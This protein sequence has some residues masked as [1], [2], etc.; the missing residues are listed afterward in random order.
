MKVWG[1]C[2]I[3]Y[4]H[5]PWGGTLEHLSLCCTHLSCWFCIRNRFRWK[6][7]QPVIH[8]FSENPPFWDEPGEILLAVSRKE[9][10]WDTR[11]LR[12]CLC[13]E[14]LHECGLS[15][16]NWEGKGRLSGWLRSILIRDC[17]VK[18]PHCNCP[19]ISSKHWFPRMSADS[20]SL[21]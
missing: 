13:P 11:D 3:V 19:S 18:V 17:C 12:F 1:D 10:E 15:P 5:E 9:P 14:P 8:I 7:L 20:T 16:V 4:T 6:A 21:S 2:V